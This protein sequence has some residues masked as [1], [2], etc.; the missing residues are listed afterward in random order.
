MEMSKKLLLAAA[1]A[2]GPLM[3]GP[4]WALPTSVT[5][6][7]LTFTNFTCNVTGGSGLTCGNIS[8]ASWLST[9]PPDAT[10]GENGMR[11]NGAFNSGSTT[12]D[13]F[14]TYDAHASGANFTDAELTF[15]GF[16]VSSVREL[17]YNAANP[18]GTPIGSINVNS[19]SPTNYTDT[20]TLSAD[21]P[22]LFITKDIS[23]SFNST[24]GPG[25]ISM[26]DQNFSTTGTTPVPEPTSLTLLGTA[27]LGLGLFG[28]R[29]KQA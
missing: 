2:A 17:I 24:L 6:G 18:T 11:F 3:A 27:L 23:L 15:N 5:S 14:I 16:A 29:R 28:R 26:I 9:S 8:A 20:T 10:A 7:N 1:V 21:V 19:P 4:A 22:D 25:T 12:E 13:V